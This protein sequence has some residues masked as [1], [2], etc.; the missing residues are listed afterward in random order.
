MCE[1]LLGLGE[2]CRMFSGN[3]CPS[4]QTNGFLWICRLLLSAFPNH[5][6]DL[7]LPGKRL[8]GQLLQ[9]TCLSPSF[10]SENWEPSAFWGQA[11]WK[12][13]QGFQRVVNIE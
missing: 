8:W 7:T 9:L 6:W 11:G 1:L 12:V 13:K 3:V 2:D 10:C 4:F 5:L